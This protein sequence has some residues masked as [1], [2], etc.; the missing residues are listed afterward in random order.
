MTEEQ[1]LQAEI[2]RIKKGADTMWEES[3]VQIMNKLPISGRI[4][5][6]RMDGAFKEVYRT[7]FYAG[8]AFF[9]KEKEKDERE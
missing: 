7:G 2:N 8:G 9:Q 4:M 1:E 6:K 3:R 5:F